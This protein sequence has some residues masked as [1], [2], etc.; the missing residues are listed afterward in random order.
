V[1]F[2][3]KDVSWSKLKKY[4][5]REDEMEF[6][7]A[8]GTV[9]EIRARW[10]LE[11]MSEEERQLVL[12]YEKTV[13]ELVD[14]IH[15]ISR[16]EEIREFRKI[17]EVIAKARKVSVEKVFEEYEEAEKPIQQYAIL[18]LDPGKIR[19]HFVK[20]QIKDDK[21]KTEPLISWLKE[22]R[23]VYDK[24]LERIKE[25]PK[26]VLAIGVGFG[27]YLEKCAR[28]TRILPFEWVLTENQKAN[29]E[30]KETVR[31]ILGGFGSKSHRYYCEECFGLFDKRKKARN[32]VKNVHG[33]K[34]DNI[35]EDI[36]FPIDKSYYRKLLSL[37]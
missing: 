25:A 29:P 9:S 23:E 34:D 7:K 15:K 36:I 20:Y 33:I 8:Q 11:K 16:E 13:E 19:D 37:I 6:I 10:A 27:D 31:K 30:F 12:K 4:V 32:H 3:E 14:M 24:Y 17:L 26:I 2:L 1:L 21:E 35:V 18:C 28:Q 5:T 22:N